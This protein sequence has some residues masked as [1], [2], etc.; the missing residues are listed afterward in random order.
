[1]KQYD[2]V[3]AGGGMAGAAAA[4]SAAK[5]NARVLL[6]EKYGFAG[7]LATAGLVGP[8]LGHTLKNRKTFVIRGF[9]EELTYSMAEKGGSINFKE[10]LKFNSIPFNAEILKVVLDELLEKYGVHLLFHTVVIDAK[11]EKNKIDH[12]EIYTRKGKEKVS[13]KMYID[14]TGDGDLINL[15]GAEWEMGR[16]SDGRVQSMGSFFRILNV[17]ENWEKDREKIS[18]NL[19]QERDKGNL[20]IYNTGFSKSGSVYKLPEFSP[21]ITRFGG[22]PISSRDLTTGEIFLRKEAIKILNICKKNSPAFKNAYLIFAPQIGI[23]ESRRITGKYTMTQED[24]IEGKKHTDSIARS[25]YWIDIHCPLGRVK[26]VH[27][28]KKDC[29]TEES[30]RA[31][32]K[33]K[34]LL[35]DKLHPPEETYYTIPFRSLFS[36]N[37][38]NLLAAGRC[39][40]ADHRAIAAIRV[41]AP[42]TA[43]GQASGIAAVLC[44]KAEKE[45]AE[46]GI[47]QI[48]KLIK[49]QGGLV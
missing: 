37:I 6:I 47:K 10:S 2:V 27:L 3:V 41:M 44:A 42:C 21:N 17:K 30:C 9:L 24:I 40:S 46:M 13:G 12:L 14:C 36:T 29:Q 35:P 18:K 11:T 26:N 23:R 16:E 49:K 25:T 15:S 8:I 19:Q 39:I 38:K 1:M 31:L 33:H 22:N 28:C 20:S 7:G 43:T 45:P 34:N 5:E 4:V 48:Q 32:E